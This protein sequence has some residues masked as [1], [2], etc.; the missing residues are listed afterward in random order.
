MAT[1]GLVGM[2]WKYDPE[3][4]ILDIYLARGR[5]VGSHRLA[6]DVVI[7]LAADG[8]VLTLEILDPQRRLPSIRDHGTGR[9]EVGPGPLLRFR[10]E[11]SLAAESDRLN[12]YVDEALSLLEK[13]IGL[14]PA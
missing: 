1:S 12:S 5:V 10:L 13:V 8:R 4:D 14:V 3:T 11:D 6:E 2:R 9:I 7:D